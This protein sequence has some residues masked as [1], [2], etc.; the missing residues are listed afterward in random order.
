M[1]HR[2]MA[3][4]TI[5][6]LKIVL[7][8]SYRAHASA[9]REL[10]ERVRPPRPFHQAVAPGPSSVRSGGGHARII[11]CSP[12]RFRVRRYAPRH[13]SV[14]YPRTSTL[15]NRCDPGSFRRNRPDRHPH[16]DRGDAR[17]SFPER[18]R[19]H[20][21]LDRRDT[22]R[23]SARAGA[24][25]DDAAGTAGAADRTHAPPARAASDRCVRRA[26]ALRV[27]VPEGHPHRRPRDRHGLVA[28]SAVAGGTLIQGGWRSR[29]PRS[30][31]RGAARGPLR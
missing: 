31:H 12:A 24:R 26:R 2:L 22:R 16:R 4:D 18:R 6:K 15:Q 19:R 1:A 23:R 27:S 11:R 20:P 29:A 17:P 21:R 7:A 28:W 14:D 30:S 3:N 13:S 25:W 9:S 8:K 5:A 10:P